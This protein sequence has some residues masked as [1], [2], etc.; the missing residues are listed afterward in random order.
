MPQNGTPGGGPADPEETAPLT[1]WAGFPELLLTPPTRWY[2]RNA[3]AVAAGCVGVVGIAVLVSAVVTVSSDSTQPGAVQPGVTASA[4]TR[5]TP[6][7]ES[8]V[9]SPT[10]TAA[11]PPP[12]VPETAATESVPAAPAPVSRPTPTTAPRWWHRLFPHRYPGG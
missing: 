4:S 8:D 12:S 1:S 7:Q 2:Q 10:A 11:K 5:P 3:A 6:T 9:A